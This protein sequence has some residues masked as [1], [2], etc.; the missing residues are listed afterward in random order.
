MSTWKPAYHKHQRNTETPIHLFSRY[1]PTTNLLQLYKFGI[2]CHKA[3]K[4][5]SMHNW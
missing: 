3:Q 4:N 1:S 2:K 5:N